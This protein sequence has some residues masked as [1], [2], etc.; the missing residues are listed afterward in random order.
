MALGEC[1]VILSLTLLPGLP[2]PE[3]IVPMSIGEN[4]KIRIIVDKNT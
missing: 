1:R 4:L 2:K 3:V